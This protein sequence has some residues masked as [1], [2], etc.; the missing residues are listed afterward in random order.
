MI[1][2]QSSCHIG[3]GDDEITFTS[4][5]ENNIY[6]GTVV[7]GEGI[8]IADRTI[9]ISSSQLDIAE[10]VTD[11]NGFYEVNGDIYNRHITFSL[12]NDFDDFY[13]DSEYTLS[14]TYDP[15]NQTINVPPLISIPF[16][17]FRIDVVNNNDLDFTV[18]CDYVIGLCN[19]YFEDDVEIHSICYETDNITR[20]INS[21]RD[22]TVLI[23]R[24]VTGTSV[25]INISNSES[26]ITETF[27]V[28]ESS[29]E[30]TIILN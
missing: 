2:S 13:V 9:I 30:E 16:S 4:F 10:I 3:G 5:G 24:A 23:F 1:L 20:N 7:D 18:S 21:S 26:S 22:G 15:S 28:N 17:V 11:S 12:V 29:Q 14:Y 19:K 25:N 8:P 6:T 27:I